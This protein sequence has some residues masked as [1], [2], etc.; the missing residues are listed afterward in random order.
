MPDKEAVKVMVRIR[1]FNKRELAGLSSDEYPTSI[2]YMHADRPKID[3]LDKH[4]QPTG[5]EF[6]F[7][8]T[9]WSMPASQKQ[10]CAKDFATQEDVFQAMGVPAVQSALSGYH[11]CIF[12]YGQTGSGKTYSMLGTP[13]DPG[14]APRIVDRLFSDL[15]Q[16]KE[17]EKSW[18]FEVEISF[19]EIYNEKVKDLLQSIKG[20]TGKRAPSPSSPK[21]RRGSMQPGS[22]GSPKEGDYSELKV[23]ESKVSGI[24][25]EG[26]TRLGEG[27]GAAT[28]AEV[29]KVMVFGMNHR[30]TAETKMNSTSSRSHAIFQI[31]LKSSN[32]SR[33][34]SRYS[35]INI[36]DLAGSERVSM[37]QVSGINLVEAT[38]INLSLSTLRRV[39][40]T[41]IDNAQKG[42][43][44][45]PPYRDALLTRILSESLGGNSNTI[46]LA[47]VSPHDSNREDTLGTLRYGMKAKMIVNNLRV[48]EEKSNVVLSAMQEEMAALR[49]QL[50][51]A[52]ASG[53][54]EE[55]ASKQQDLERKIEEMQ[56]K[57][58]QRKEHKKMM[59]QQ[60]IQMEEMTRAVEERKREVKQMME[61]GVAEAHAAKLAEA[62]AAEEA[63]RL[64]KEREQLLA[65]E[66][67]KAQ[68]KLREGDELAERLERERKEVE[69]QTKQ[70]RQE[71]DELKKK[72]FKMAFSKAFS[73]SKKGGERECLAG[74]RG[75]VEALERELREAQRTVAESD[76][77]VRLAAAA[78]KS[79]EMAARQAEAVQAELRDRL[80][81]TLDGL[82]AD[83]LRLEAEGRTLT[84]AM[85]SKRERL[86]RAEMSVK[87]LR[88]AN[89]QAAE[90]DR[91]HQRA[92]RRRGE[93]YRRGLMHQED[94]LSQLQ[95]D[96][97]VAEME[98]N[99]LRK[100]NSRLRDLTEQR[101]AAA[102]R[103]V[104]E[105]EAL[106]EDTRALVMH[107][108]YCL[109][110]LTV[111][112]QRAQWLQAQ[113]SPLRDETK[114]SKL[115]LS[116]GTARVC[117]GD[118]AMRSPSPAR[119]REA[120][121]SPSVSS[122]PRRRWQSPR[123]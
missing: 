43:N 121:L 24:Y 87:E 112:A 50:E 12:A 26:L 105:T 22:P 27:T 44:N 89:Q 76:S 83:V 81:G 61:E 49:A 53:E 15:E 79:A 34:V 31:C 23:R 42:Q 51:E 82:R 28:A 86:A 25:V 95:Q 30:A 40:D 52:A 64:V 37:S 104:A 110:E 78:Q 65:E 119:R 3:I 4:G 58:A 109:R 120:P 118:S 8:T 41:L 67:S 55:I 100:E 77:R 91:R 59:E 5:E 9:F 16:K 94:S 72:Q 101:H 6:E 69:E 99:V 32:A 115:L 13:D 66:H 17:Q 106:E 2:V 29:K 113:T 35:H 60:K 122:S 75:E 103:A 123:R 96:A 108:D 71:H 57:E 107:Q 98:V 80:P 7:N 84:A 74:R 116:L 45:R 73:Y 92:E 46:M 1:P 10:V 62:Q 93:G 111:E 19:M 14:V 11:C 102:R 97:D 36:V 33:G 39:I 88:V 18:K 68:E 63:A 56:E 47:T 85:P 20:I 90:D 114:L 48:N 54:S 70:M 117:G 38:R 21:K